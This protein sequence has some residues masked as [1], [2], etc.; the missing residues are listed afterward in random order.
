MWITIL[1]SLDVNA[2]TN[3]KYIEVL[4]HE[5][6]IAYKKDDASF[7]NLEQESFYL[8]AKHAM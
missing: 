5:H 7:Q 8:K 4:N 2:L 6:F 1:W 3:A